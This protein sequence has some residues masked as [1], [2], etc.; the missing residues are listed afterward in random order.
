MWDGVRHS[1][2]CIEVGCLMDWVGFF[3]FAQS[4]STEPRTSQVIHSGNEP[5]A[6][7]DVTC[8]VFFF[9]LKQASKQCFLGVG[10]KHVSK[11]QCHTAITTHCIYAK[12]QP[13][14]TENVFDSTCAKKP[15]PLWK[16]IMTSALLK[17]ESNLGVAFQRW[18]QSR[19]QKGFKTDAIW[20]GL[21]F[22]NITEFIMFECQLIS[23]SGGFSIEEREEDPP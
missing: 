16:S 21:P 2:I 20:A 5:V 13:W 18:N 17:H 11:L 22:S 10:L 4:F 15:G 14:S 19:A 3:F 9:A 23:F 7:S 8:H 1:K 6:A 12:K